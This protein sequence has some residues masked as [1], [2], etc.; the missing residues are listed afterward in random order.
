MTLSSGP[1]GESVP[2]LNGSNYSEWKEQ[3]MLT[4]M[5]RILQPLTYSKG[6]PFTPTLLDVAVI[7]GLHP[8]DITLSMAY[9][10][11]KF[12]DFRLYPNSSRPIPLAAILL[13]K[14]MLKPIAF[15]HWKIVFDDFLGTEP[16]SIPPEDV[17]DEDPT[18]SP[19][20]S[21]LL[22]HINSS[23]SQSSAGS[24]PPSFAKHIS[25]QKTSHA[26]FTS[27]LRRGM[28]DIGRQACR[29]ARLDKKTEAERKRAEVSTGKRERKKEKTTKAS[30]SGETE[31]AKGDREVSETTKALK[32]TDEGEK[33]KENEKKDQRKKMIKRLAEVRFLL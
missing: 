4:A 13:Q 8:H 22:I 32:Q 24:S 12:K 23:S 31:D 17:S 27:S 2:I 19:S 5:S 26:C 33:E 6:W 25:S 20:P 7:V 14:V 16:L 1:I 21:S 18:S 9:N 10:P 3:I 15:Q 11:D 30:A 28:S 29:E